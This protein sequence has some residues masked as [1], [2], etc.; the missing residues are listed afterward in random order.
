MRLLISKQNAM[1][2]GT[3]SCAK[4]ALIAKADETDQ[5]CGAL[6]LIAYQTQP[7]CY[8]LSPWVLMSAFRYSPPPFLLARGI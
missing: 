3:A 2:V 7:T 1:S 4:L 5:R 8:S 6:T